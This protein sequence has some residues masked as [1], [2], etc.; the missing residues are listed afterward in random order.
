MISG[1]IDTAT[2]R[3]IS[4]G[5]IAELWKQPRPTIYSK[6]ARGKLIAPDWLVAVPAGK[7][8][9]EGVPVWL[10]DRFTD[11]PDVID[12]TVV[13]GLPRLIGMDEVAVCMD[14]QRRTVEAMRSRG[15]QDV[16]AP[17]P[18]ERLGRTPVWWAAAWQE[19]A[20]LTGRPFDLNRLLKL[21][22][23]RRK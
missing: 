18:Y 10:A 23:E 22:R 14:V 9:D 17:E 8:L 1:E 19:F 21:D 12:G 7:S 2:V 5:G 15:R 20:R 3:L 11:E 6:W 4:L 13:E 16:I